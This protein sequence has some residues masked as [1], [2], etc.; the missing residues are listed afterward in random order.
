M[1]KVRGLCSNEI[2]QIDAGVEHALGDSGLR[3]L[4][5]SEESPANQDSTVTFFDGQNVVVN[6]NDARLTP[7]QRAR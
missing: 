6:L 1:N 2:I 7:K 5:T 4:F 3:V